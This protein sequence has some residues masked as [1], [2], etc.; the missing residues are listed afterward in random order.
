MTLEWDLKWKVRFNPH[1]IGISERL[2]HISKAEG[3]GEMLRDAGLEA[4]HPLLTQTER[5]LNATHDYVSIW[6]FVHLNPRGE[7]TQG[8]GLFF[9]DWREGEEM[10]GK[11]ITDFNFWS[12]PFL[13][14]NYMNTHSHSTNT[15]CVCH[16]ARLISRGP[17]EA[18]QHGSSEAH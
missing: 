11:C 1:W 13:L 14:S 15:G 18:S 3:T 10:K 17:P 5:H 2:N 8:R 4:Q 12:S 9:Q 7:T 16:T 6:P